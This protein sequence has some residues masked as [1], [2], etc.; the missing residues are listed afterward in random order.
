[1]DRQGLQLSGG[2]AAVQEDAFVDGEFLMDLLD[3]TP[4]TAAEQQQRL[5]LLEVDVDVD[6]VAA[7]DRLSRVMR[8]GG[9]LDD[10][11]SDLDGGGGSASAM[12]ASFEYWARAELPTPP[13][14]GHD[15]G[16]GGWCG[17]DAGGE[18]EFREPC[19]YYAY[20]YNESSHVE[21]PYSPLW[22]IENE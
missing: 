10:M 11:M 17:V 4:S 12:Q 14:M 20:G 6:D 3:D 2:G 15:M 9:E 18:Y 8:G 1:M 5:L 19:G 22:E 21:Q 7:D 16:G 13:A